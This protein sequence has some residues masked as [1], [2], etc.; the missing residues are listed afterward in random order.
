[1]PFGNFEAAHTVFAL[2]LTGFWS[3]PVGPGLLGASMAV[4]GAMKNQK[5]A[6]QGFPLNSVVF[7]MVWN[8]G[9]GG[10][11]LDLHCARETEI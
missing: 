1:V 11:F 8:W 6:P 9:G 3:G 4:G 5:G 7:N 2:A 10:F